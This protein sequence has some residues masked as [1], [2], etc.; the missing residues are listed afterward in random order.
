MEGRFGRNLQRVV[1]IFTARCKHSISSTTR[2][3]E[4]NDTFTYLQRPAKMTGSG[5]TARCK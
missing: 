3:R 5:T 1:I 2:C 4:Q